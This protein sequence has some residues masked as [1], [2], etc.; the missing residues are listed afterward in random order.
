[1]SATM[2]KDAWKRIEKWCRRHHPQLLEILNPG[3]SKKELAAVENTIGQ[4]LPVD[5]R[6]SL[7]IHDGQSDKSRCHFLF[8][9]LNFATCERISWEY[10][11]WKGSD[12]GDSPTNRTFYPKDAIVHRYHEDNWIPVAYEDGCGNCLAVDLAPGPAGIPGQVIDFGAN[13]YDLGVLAPSWGHFLLSYAKLLESGVLT[14]VSSDIDYWHDDFY[15]LFERAAL[16]A[17]VLWAM[18][19]RWPIVDFAKTW[20][21]SD[22]VGL[23]R[24]IDETRDFSTTPILADALEDAGCEN[25][26]IL[27]HCRDPKC[28]H[29][30]GCWVVDSILRG[31][32]ENGRWCNVFPGE[33]QS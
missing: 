7:L 13:I 5:V 24:R 27:N 29:A 18:D 30:K 26:A 31:K 2:V 9:Q 4:P 20:R 19:G 21:T 28:K 16:D 23:A 6:T 11:H 33:P 15:P 3:A 17:L 12:R 10:S 14:D 32:V 1:M 8:G 25:M 22:V